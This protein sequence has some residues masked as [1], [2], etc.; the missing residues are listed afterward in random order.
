M[1]DVDNKVIKEIA[2][3]APILASLPKTNRYHIPENYFNEVEIQI[4]CQMTILTVEDDSQKV[5]PL[6]YF[7][8]VEEVIIN[9]IA[10]Q[11]QDAKII[12]MPSRKINYQRYAAIVIAFLA[13]IAVLRFATLE[14]NAEMASQLTQAEILDYMV[15]N[16]E[17]FDINMLIDHELIEEN[18]LDGLSYIYID[19][20]SSDF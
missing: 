15:D 17:D 2:E 18:T 20:E 6:D 1:N 13:C 9:R 8:K 7:S 19:D 16:A 14:R 4:L 5:I 10:D 11:D 12:E 3:M